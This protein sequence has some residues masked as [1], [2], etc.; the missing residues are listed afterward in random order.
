MA[1]RSSRAAK[2]D[3][4]SI[5]PELKSEEAVSVKF[6]QVWKALKGDKFAKYYVL[7]KVIRLFSRS[8]D[9]FHWNIYTDY[10][11]GEMEQLAK[12]H[13]LLLQPADYV[14][15]GQHLEKSKQ[16]IKPLHPNWIALY[17]TILQLQP[18]AVVEAGC[19]NGMHLHNL[20]VLLPGITVTGLDRSAGQLEYLKELNPGLAGSIKNFDL[21]QSLPQ[22]LV[23]S[24]DVCYS[25]AVIMHIKT[26]DLHMQA[27][28]NMF[29]IATKQVV[30]MENWKHHHFMDDI[31]NL[32]SR[33]LIP[34]KQ[35]YLYYRV[36]QELQKPHIM[37]CSSVPLDYPVL[38]NYDTLRNE[39]TA[40]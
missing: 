22:D 28:A 23:S 33:K 13:T 1:M 17:E 4:E 29:S 7:R 11:R 2:C 8:Q 5:S 40:V 19:G 15:R 24:A 31:L 9:D 37:V 30:L 35:V 12:E 26:D 18:Q 20:Q 39:V 36:S 32:Y 6:E 3:P 10:Y 27:L 14:F 34:W 38:D 25:Q 16:S 21:T